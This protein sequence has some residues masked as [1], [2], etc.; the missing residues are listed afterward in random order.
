MDMKESYNMLLQKDEWKEKCAIILERDN[1]TCKHCNCIGIH[2]DTFL[3][4]PI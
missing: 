3:K 4:F 2:N 1:Y